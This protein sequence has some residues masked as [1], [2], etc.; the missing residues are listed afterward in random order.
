MLKASYAA[1]GVMPWKLLGQPYLR[2]GK[3]VPLHLQLWPTARCNAACSWCTSKDIDRKQEL[4][5]GEIIEL[6]RHF[7]KLGTQAVTVAGGGEPTLHHHFATIARYINNYGMKLGLETNGLNLK[8]VAAAVGGD[9]DWCRVSVIEAYRGHLDRIVELSELLPQTDFSLSFTVPDDV[10]LDFALSVAQLA[11][12]SPHISGVKFVQ[13]LYAQDNDAID[14]LAGQLDGFTKAFINSPVSGRG[15]KDCWVSLIRPMVGPDG[16]VYPCC[17]V[18]LAQEPS[19]RLPEAL[20]MC[21]WREYVK[22]EPFN[23]SACRRCLYGNYNEFIGYA[24]NPPKH[25]EFV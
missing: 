24:M 20:R 25:L 10:D 13:D 17:G 9:C 4:F 7:A 19:R 1:N 6:L 2:D 8:N 14:Q 12:K 15:S 5:I 21:H 23:G 18:S 3:V 22:P 16:Y 11:E